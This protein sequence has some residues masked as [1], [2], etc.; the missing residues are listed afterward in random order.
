MHL[1][2]ESLEK[3]TWWW[4]QR[5]DGDALKIEKKSQAWGV[6]NLEPEKYKKKDSLRGSRI[7]REEICC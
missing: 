7:V 5:L 1:A 2:V 3:A 4:M 6:E